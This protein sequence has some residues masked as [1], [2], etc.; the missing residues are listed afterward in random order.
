M[1]SHH[2]HQLLPPPSLSA[3]FFP[4][5]SIYPILIARPCLTNGD[6]PLASSLR[7]LSSLPLASS[8]STSPAS[9]GAHVWAR[10]YRCCE[11]HRAGKTRRQSLPRNAPR[12]QSCPPVHPKALRVSQWG[13]PCVP[14]DQVMTFSLWLQPPMQVGGQVCSTVLVASRACQVS[15]SLARTF[16]NP[17]FLNGPLSRQPRPEAPIP[18]SRIGGNLHPSLGTVGTRSLGVP[19]TRRRLSPSYPL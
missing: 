14:S 12:D 4:L 11:L 16:A 2:H 7:F 19:G 1:F 5:L 10:S 17:T 18:S 6:A 13:K 8:P 3:V 9:H 15:L